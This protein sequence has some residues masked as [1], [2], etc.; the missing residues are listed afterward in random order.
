[1]SSRPDWTLYQT[2]SQKDKNKK[3]FA[4]SCPPPDQPSESPL[5]WQVA[6]RTWRRREHM[7]TGTHPTESGFFSMSSLEEIQRYCKSISFLTFPSGLIGYHYICVSQA[8]IDFLHI[9]DPTSSLHCLWGRVSI[10]SVV[11]FIRQAEA[12][13]NWMSM[14]KDTQLLA[15]LNPWPKSLGVSFL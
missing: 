6:L 4:V 11:C 14:P 7:N 10:A 8:C 3:T 2:L 13:R 15:K 1:M 5:L 12:Q 9:L